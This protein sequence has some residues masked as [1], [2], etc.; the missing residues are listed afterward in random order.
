MESRLFW[1][2]ALHMFKKEK[3]KELKSGS[4]IDLVVTIY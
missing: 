1:P 3:L 4:L 2:E